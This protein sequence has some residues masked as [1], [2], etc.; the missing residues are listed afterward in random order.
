GR[1][2][3]HAQRHTGVQAALAEVLE[4]RR[5][6]TEDA[7]NAPCCADLHLA[8]RYVMQVGKLALGSRDRV[9]MRAW[10]RVPEKRRETIGNLVGGRVLKLAGVLVGLLPGDVKLV[11]QEAFPQ[12]VPP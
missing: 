8:Q 11:H 12:A 6:L 9:A 7:S 10:R 4:E 5:L 3:L 1:D 2:V